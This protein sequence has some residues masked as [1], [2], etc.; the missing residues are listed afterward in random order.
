MKKLGKP[1]IL[2]VNG[3]SF[4]G[5]A[6][7]R[8]LLDQG[9]DVAVLGEYDQPA[10]DFIQ[11]FKA[12]AFKYLDYSLVSEL[13]SR[14]DRIDYV[15]IL[16]NDLAEAEYKTTDF[17]RILSQITN[18][19]DA[20]YAK[21]A[22][23]V[24][25]TSMRWEAE[26]KKR[27]PCDTSGYTR[28][29]VEMFSEKTVKEYISKTGL[30]SRIVRLGEVYGKG[31]DVTKDTLLASI[32]KQALDEPEIVV[33]G[34]TLQFDYYIHALDA[35]LGLLKALFTKETAGK[36]YTLANP[37]E[38]SLLSLAHKVIE[39]G[40]TAK[41]VRFE[42]DKD[43]SEEPLYKNA[44][45]LAPNIE[46]LGW[47]PKISFERGLAQTVEYF[48]EVTGHGKKRQSEIPT[49]SGQKPKDAEEETVHD[50]QTA[51]IGDD[52]ALSVKMDEVLPVE[53]SKERERYEKVQK[54]K[55]VE[56]QREADERLGKVL[57]VTGYTLLA[58][59]TLALYFTVVVP[60]AGIVRSYLKIGALSKAY[61]VAYAADEQANLTRIQAETEAQVTSL[62]FYS[63]RLDFFWQ[64]AGIKLSIERVLNLM[65]GTR[66]L[67]NGVEVM[68]DNDVQASIAFKSAKLWLDNSKCVEVN[69]DFCQPF[70][71][72]KTINAELLE[73]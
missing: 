29:D 68:K 70:E 11:E 44:F 28:E 51:S 22:K 71:E 56:K 27:W 60:A 19:L 17:V 7:A 2:I 14:F 64:I 67:M 43:K 5:R 72:L 41:R 34:E 26:L 55:K 21:Q 8:A 69:Q 61:L 23:V 50:S 53:M 46:A 12:Q 66:E 13:T 45:S 16:L 37:E 54:L 1:S 57:K 65:Y 47:K 6:L 63:S 36:T 20:A 31:M 10:R 3:V 15:V 62:E 58:V 24:L 52:L 48:R 25:V 33:P 40:V 4:L 18:V 59:A 32:I 39:T 38:I 49:Q 30:D 42:S 73:E 9:G 35:V